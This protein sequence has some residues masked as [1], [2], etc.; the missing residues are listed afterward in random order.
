MTVGRLTAGDVEDYLGPAEGRY[1]GSGFRRVRQRL[2]AIALTGGPESTRATATASVGY[3]GDW[4]AKG[5][6]GLVPHLSTIDAL[7]LAAR[8]AELLLT[9]AYGLDA[10]AR[11]RMWLRRVVIRAGDRPQEDLARLPVHGTVRPAES[12]AV[13][14]G[15]R[16]SVVGVTIGSMD[17]RCEVQHEDQGGYRPSPGALYEDADTALGAPDGQYYAE[18]FRWRGQRVTHLAVDAPAGRADAEVTL[19]P[20]PGESAGTGLEAAY[21]P[22]ASMVDAIAVMGQLAQILMYE[23]DGL[24]RG[25][26]DTL[27]LRRAELATD[28]PLRAVDRAFPVHARVADS[29]LV[30]IDDR[31]W[32]VCDLSYG[33]HG[34]TGTFSVTHRLPDRGTR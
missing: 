14:D 28:L 24:T 21:A 23:L 32:R 16:T 8:T 13:A 12:V 26:S 22:S 30:D 25:G 17:V 33:F 29:R 6:G 18:L 5:T 19:T 15:L 27:W 2:T 34:I 9:H 31:R 7:V 1:F 20:A 11:S 10:G 3:P 4:S